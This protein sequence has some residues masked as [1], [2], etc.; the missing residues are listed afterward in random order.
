M[1]RQTK[2]I[3]A[4]LTAMTMTVGAVGVSAYAEEPAA[5]QTEDT[6]KSPTGLTYEI[7]DPDY[8][9]EIDDLYGYIP[10]EDIVLK[11][12]NT[13]LMENPT[14]HREPHE[15]KWY[16]KHIYT[17]TPDFKIDRHIADPRISSDDS[18]NAAESLRLIAEQGKADDVEARDGKVRKFTE[19]DVL[20]TILVANDE[21][22]ADAIN[23]FMSSKGLR[24][25][26]VQVTPKQVALHFEDKDFT[27]EDVIS[28]VTALNN[29]FGLLPGGLVHDDYG[30]TELYYDSSYMGGMSDDTF[31]A[32]NYTK[33]PEERAKDEQKVSRYEAAAEGEVADGVNY[34]FNKYLGILLIDGEGT[35]TR[36]QISKVIGNCNEV[37]KDTGVYLNYIIF[38]RKVKQAGE[39][40]D[41]YADCDRWVYEYTNDFYP[42]R[43]C[44]YKDSLVAEEFDNIKKS[45]EATGKLFSGYHLLM[46]DDDVDAKDLLDGKVDI[47][48]FDNFSKRPGYTSQPTEEA[49][50]PTQAVKGAAYADS[51]K[52]TLIGD[53]DVSGDVGLS[54]VV[55]VTKFNLSSE[56]Y[57][58]KNET[59]KANADMNKDSVINGLDT[60][61]LIENQLGK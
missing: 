54:D 29:E 18:I 2:A 15:D 53:A 41:D 6:A 8:M 10:A 7:D 23:T 40:T 3:V 59:A 32:Y 4:F 20:W 38:G 17:D 43:V 51:S 19:V 22:S 14:L 28:A 33:D 58:L 1:K 61:A 35:V 42:F 57:P 16:I 25:H 30:T 56:S 11:Y 26:V 39:Y 50:V 9:Y 27:N 48:K 5:S 31:T 13:W 37:A 49:A 36:N 24:S 47:Y 60:S 21:V 55:A 46:I 12:F 44:T 45:V 34:S 52:A